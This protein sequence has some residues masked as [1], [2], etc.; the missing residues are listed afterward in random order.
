MKL[1]S[2]LQPSDKWKPDKVE[3]T[4]TLEQHAPFKYMDAKKRVKAIDAD[5]KVFNKGKTKTEKKS[6]E[7]ELHIKE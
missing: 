2:G 7:S 1:P 3:F 5:W 6:A 4:A